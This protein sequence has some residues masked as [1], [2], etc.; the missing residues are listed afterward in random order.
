MGTY[1]SSMERFRPPKICGFQYYCTS[2]NFYLDDGHNLSIFNVFGGVCW[3]LMKKCVYY[4][5]G[6]L[7]TLWY[8][9]FK[10]LQLEFRSLLSPFQHWAWSQWNSV[11][12]QSSFN[13]A[14]HDLRRNANTGPVTIDACLRNHQYTAVTEVFCTFHWS[15][16][17]KIR[18]IIQ[19]AHSIIVAYWL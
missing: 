15:G 16:P 6:R 9:A 17:D 18:G 13:I 19:Y 4:T 10:N 1:I 5:E 3:L 7:C 2:C 8:S 14:N 12:I 11:R